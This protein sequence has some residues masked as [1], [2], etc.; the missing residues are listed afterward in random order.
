MKTQFEHGSA[1]ETSRESAVASAERTALEITV[2][3][4]DAVLDVRHLVP[5]R[6]L[7]IGDGKA[8][9]LVVSTDALPVSEFPLL[10][11]EGGRFVLTFSDGQKGEIDLGDGAIHPLPWFSSHKGTSPD[12]GLAKCF[13]FTLPQSAKVTLR[14]DGVTLAIASVTPPERLA[15]TAG[16]RDYRY[17]AA[18]LS[19]SVVVLIVLALVFAFGS[20]APEPYL[21]AAGVEAESRGAR[22]YGAESPASGVFM[23]T[24]P[25]VLGALSQADVTQALAPIAA[26]IDG[27]LGSADPSTAVTARLAID[28]AG[29]VGVAAVDAT[30]AGAFEVRSCLGA[31]FGK[32]QLAPP[33]DGRATFDL[34]LR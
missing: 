31:A 11:V 8:V 1:K 9:D 22:L 21:P 23:V 16:P 24:E 7:V 18:I 32:M 14:F 29:N 33:I 2:S 15:D 6:G 12:P 27:C 26:E 5:P 4:G 20:T 17:A 13:R 3:Y 19:A 30:G 25:V 10:R 28:A 34:R